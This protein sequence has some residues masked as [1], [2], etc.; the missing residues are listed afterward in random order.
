M[1][2]SILRLIPAGQGLPDLGGQVLALT[3]ASQ[4]PGL[5][6]AP[7][8]ALAGAR[9]VLGAR[10]LEAVEPLARRLAAHGY[11]VH[12]LA[13]DVSDRRDM[14]RFVSLAQAWQGRL[15]VLINSAGLRAQVPA[16]LAALDFAAWELQLDLGLRATLHGIAASLPLLQARGRGQIVNL[17]QRGDSALQAATRQALR[18]LTEGLR[19]ELR[20]N[21]SPLR[22][23]LVEIASSRY[24]EIGLAAAAQA[25]L[26]V[27]SEPRDE[28]LVRD[29][30]HDRAPILGETV[31]RA[32]R[33]N[34]TRS[35]ALDG[36]PLFAETLTAVS[37]P[38]HRFP[39]SPSG[40]LAFLGEN[41]ARPRSSGATL[42]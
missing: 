21:A 41:G 42:N 13:V 1:H 38:D 39:S 10:R 28:L 20:A 8:L 4:G 31:C 34:Q 30:D 22:V 14:Q 16:P 6:A 18:G 2:A 25:L 5:A 24:D 17:V 9:L 12:A 3:D 35:T 33:F 11:K 40:L 15:D 26:R 36:D 32:H 37:D 29:P 23:S 27:I 7:L 19:R